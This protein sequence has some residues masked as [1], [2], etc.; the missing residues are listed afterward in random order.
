VRLSLECFQTPL[1]VESSFISTLPQ[2]LPASLTSFLPS[3]NVFPLTKIPT[4]L[5]LLFSASNLYASLCAPPKSAKRR[6]ELQ[7]TKDIPLTG[8]EQD[9]RNVDRVDAGEIDIRFVQGVQLVYS[10]GEDEDGED[11]CGCAWAEVLW[12]FRCWERAYEPA[13][14]GLWNRAF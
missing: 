9:N 1:F 12:N 5:P 11:E 4:A 6:Q 13:D 3:F 10:G 2:E 7:R 8:S 14:T